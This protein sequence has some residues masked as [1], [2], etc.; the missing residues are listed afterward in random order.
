MDRKK[1]KSAIRI[2]ALRKT[3]AEAEAA[4]L[5]NGVIAGTSMRERLVASD[6]DLAHAD[7]TTA[8]IQRTVDILDRG[9]AVLKQQQSEMISAVHRADRATQVVQEK[10]NE[11]GQK[12]ERAVIEDLISA[13]IVSR[14]GVVKRSG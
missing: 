3:K 12:S 1:L 5:R 4:R 2:L 7:L 11:S 13:A 9:L 14:S 10:L 8:Y 6:C